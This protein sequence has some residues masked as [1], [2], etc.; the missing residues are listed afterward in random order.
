MSI[1]L[2][3]R[4]ENNIE[5]PYI[6]FNDIKLYYRVEYVEYNGTITNFYNNFEIK[7]YRPFGI[8]KKKH[9]FILTDYIFHSN[10]DILS[11]YYSKDHVKYY[12]TEGYNKYLIDKAD[13][14]KR[15]KRREELKQNII[16]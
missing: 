10:F 7:Y 2:T 14:I 6:I 5:P 11:D 9:K 13:D 8:G 12:V 16:L 3:K 1:D 15:A 4:K